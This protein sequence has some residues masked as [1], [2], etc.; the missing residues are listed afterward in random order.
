MITRRYLRNKRVI[1]DNSEESEMMDADATRVKGGF[2]IESGGDLGEY[3]DMQAMLT[4]IK[5]M[6]RE[7]SEKMVKEWE[8]MFVVH[9]REIVSSMSQIASDVEQRT[10]QKIEAVSKE[11]SLI[12]DSTNVHVSKQCEE[13]KTQVELLKNQKQIESQNNSEEVY[14]TRINNRQSD[15][16]IENTLTNSD[17]R[18]T[19]ISEPLTR[20]V[21]CNGP[22]EMT[23]ERGQTCC[24][25]NNVSIQENVWNGNSVGFVREIPNQPIDLALPIFE[26]KPDQ[27]AQAHLNSLGE[28]LQIKNIPPPLHLAIPRRS[29]KG[30]SVMTGPSTLAK[31]EGRVFTRLKKR[32]G[33]PER[34]R[35]RAR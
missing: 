24:P 17:V 28:Y 22:N 1:G 7:E 19:D 29:L 11:I 30:I 20:E 32:A 4:C 8:N 16:S 5:E 27:N 34:R 13:L 10:D 31:K 12:T 33:K 21:S 18:I 3:I 6:F 2:M 26:N 23:A 25:H 35:R 14:C 15:S 9:T